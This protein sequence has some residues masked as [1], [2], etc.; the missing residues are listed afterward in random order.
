M[1]RLGLDPV[2]FDV[3]LRHHGTERGTDALQGALRFGIGHDC[4]SYGL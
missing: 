1:Q 2:D 4:L 3:E